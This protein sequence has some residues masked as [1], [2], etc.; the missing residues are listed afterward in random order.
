MNTENTLKIAGFAE[1]LDEGVDPGDGALLEQ[2]CV[3]LRCWRG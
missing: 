3:I 2:G 1:M